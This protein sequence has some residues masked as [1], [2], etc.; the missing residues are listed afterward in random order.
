MSRKVFNSVL[1]AAVA[2]FIGT[3]AVAA[4]HSFASEYDANQP[5]TFSGTV[6]KM[7]WVNPHSWIY[8]DVKKPDGS[9]EKWAVEAG[10]TGTLVRAGFT[11]NSLPAGT[12]IR[13][14]G[15]RAKDG[16]LRAN[17]RD[18]TLPDGKLIFVGS[19]GT[20]APYDKK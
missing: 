4:H 6:T 1:I 12:E 11:K 19:S 5:I 10:P 3:A 8:V 14:N 9:V 13:V 17:G 15:Y 16:A 18:I 7:D 20:G 2:V